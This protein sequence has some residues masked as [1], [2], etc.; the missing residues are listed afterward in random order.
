[1]T[2]QV[3]AQLVATVR[4]FRRRPRWRHILALIAGAVLLIAGSGFLAVRLTHHVVAGTPTLGVAVGLYA[5]GVLL[6]AW[7]A[8]GGFTARLAWWLPLSA[9]LGLVAGLVFALSA[10]FSNEADSAFYDGRDRKSVV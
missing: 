3:D 1:M 9:V 6:F 7:G 2:R 4:A 5:A 8:A 10:S